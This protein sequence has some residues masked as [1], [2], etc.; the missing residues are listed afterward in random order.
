MKIKSFFI[1][2]SVLALLLYGCAEKDVYVESSFVAMDTIINIKVS[3]GEYDESAIISECEAMLSDIESIISATAEG[4]ETSIA[5]TDIDMLLDVSPVFIEILQI[6]LSSYE[7]TEGT[8]DITVGSLKELWEKCSAEG[9]EPTEDDIKTALENVGC[10]KLTLKENSLYKD[11]KETKLDFGAIGKGYAAERITDLLEDRGVSGAILSLGGNVALVG[12]KQNGKPYKVGVKD[13]ENTNDVVGYL[14]LDGGFVSVS[15][16]YER[17]I[18]IGE[19]RYNHIIDPRTGYPADSGL[20]S[21]S[22]ISEDGALAD[23]LSTALFVMGKDEAIEFYNSGVCDFEAVFVTDD[24]VFVTDGLEGRYT[25]KKGE[26]F[27]TV[28]EKALR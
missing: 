20:H 10:D 11:F 5:N 28:G 22:V 15:G 7:L 13:P 26:S 17:Y 16:D 24:G 23:V 2:L 8:F 27:T 4:S 6:S 19:K 18:E 14:S 12:S 25:P 3:E 9:K 1:I 21:V